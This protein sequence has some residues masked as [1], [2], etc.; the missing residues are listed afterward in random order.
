[1]LGPRGVLGHYTVTQAMG[2][3]SDSYS[4]GEHLHLTSLQGLLL[5][6]NLDTDQRLTVLVLEQEL[7]TFS[8]KVDLT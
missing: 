1:M 6:S 5:G 7:F 4:K 2:T 3:E 8:F